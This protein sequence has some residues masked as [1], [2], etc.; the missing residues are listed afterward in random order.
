M[1]SGIIKALNQS[2]DCCI[3]ENAMKLYKS[4][5]A[6]ES[7]L[8]EAQEKVTR[9]R[10]ELAQRRD[11]LSKSAGGNLI[12]SLNSTLAN[13]SLNTTQN[14]IKLQRLT[15]QLSEAQDLLSKADDYELLSLKVDIAKQNLQETILWRDRMNRQNRMIQPPTVSVI[16]D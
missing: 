8:T 9:S 2:N 11:Q 3:T 12:G 6:S 13:Y 10:I 14:K 5:R 4:G 1:A 7:D 15:E 16:G